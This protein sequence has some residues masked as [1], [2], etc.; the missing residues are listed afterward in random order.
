MLILISIACVFVGTRK[1][2]KVI[3]GIIQPLTLVTRRLHQLSEGDVHSAERKILQR[4]MR[5]G[6]WQLPKTA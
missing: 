2:S 1:T 5:P 4:K 3:T 6:F